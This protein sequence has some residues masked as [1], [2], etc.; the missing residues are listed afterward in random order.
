LN[1]EPA[2]AHVP[3]HLFISQQSASKEARSESRIITIVCMFAGH[4]FERRN[5]H[6]WLPDIEG[7]VTLAITHWSL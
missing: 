2:W 3:I 7:T 5:A 4:G 1:Q 6:S